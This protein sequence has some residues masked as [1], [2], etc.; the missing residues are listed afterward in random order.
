M[1]LLIMLFFF[2]FVFSDI[3]A[4]DTIK[5][6]QT[7]I[8]FTNRLIVAKKVSTQDAITYEIDMRLDSLANKSKGDVLL[9]STVK[10]EIGNVLYS[11]WK[12]GK[13]LG[14]TVSQAYF[15]QTGLQTMTQMDIQNG[16]LLVTVGI[17]LVKPAEFQL[18][19]FE[20]TVKNKKLLVD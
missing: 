8:R 18:L 13:L 12:S 11:Y 3:S 4:Q 2:L 1:K 16:R 6:L 19:Q 9:I 5:K 7:P 20:Q 17:A 15:I 10:A 14:S